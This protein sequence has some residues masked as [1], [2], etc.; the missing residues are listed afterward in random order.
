MN[1]QEL[2]INYENILAEK[3]S[4]KH[5][6][7]KSEILDYQDQVAEIIA[8]MNAERKDDNS[9]FGFLNFPYQDIKPYLKI[10]EKLARVY[11][12]II[13]VGIGGSSLGAKAIHQALHHTYWNDISNQNRGDIPKMHFLENVDPEQTFELLSVINLSQTL[14]V[15]VSKSGNTPETLANFAILRKKLISKHGKNNFAQHI[16][17]ISE[18]G[19]GALHTLAEK[20]GYQFFPV[21][22]AVSG[23]YSVLGAEGLVPAALAGIDIKKLLAG[24]AAMDKRCKK[25]KLLDN[26]AALLAVI[27]Y[28]LYSKKSKNNTVLFSYAHHLS[29][30]VDWYRQILAES[31]GKELNEQNQRVY[32]GITPLKAVG[33]IDQHSQLQLY[34]EGP[35]DKLIIFIAP[36]QYHHDFKISSLG[37]DIPGTDYL[38]NQSYAK[39]FKV[40]ALTT[41]FAL[42][43]Y[44]RPNIA[45][46]IPQIDAHSMGQILFMLEVQVAILGKLLNINPFNQPGVELGKQYTKTFMK[47]N[48]S[49]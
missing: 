37:A 12:Y 31:T 11:K 1:K 14:V 4:T 8:K 48:E 7:R 20:E 2:K 44:H 16:I 26:P 17:A 46:S 13:V 3:I 24:A 23:R 43:N 30:I 35:N 29:R 41:Q 27:Q 49:F 25:Q 21:N 28:L 19:N 5:G 6:L 18:S 9:P 36:E 38:N 47:S 45:I 32:T 33:V 15:V 40:E 34:N 22:K 10:A 42:T 39:L